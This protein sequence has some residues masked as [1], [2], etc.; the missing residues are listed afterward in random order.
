LVLL[1]PGC[2]AAM[3]PAADATYPGRNGRIAYTVVQG[4]SPPTA[5]STETVLPNGRGRRTLGE[6]GSLSWAASGRLLL[7]TT[8]TWTD[9]V[10]ARRS[11]LADD[12]GQVLHTIPVPLGPDGVPVFSPTALSPDGRTVAG[13]SFT[14]RPHAQPEQVVDWIWTI[15][16]DG[17]QLRRVARGARPRWTAN[18]RRIVFQRESRFGDY[19]GIASMRSDG[20]FKR[21]LIGGPDARFLDLAPDG[22]RLLWHGHRRGAGLFTSDL[23][24]GHPH[25]ISRRNTQGAATWSPDGTKILFAVDDLDLRGTFIARATGGSRQRLLRR[26]RFELAWQPLPRTPR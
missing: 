5:F 26:P 8:L 18:G 6:F 25:L 22:R 13:V 16:T 17:S 12:Q 10:A 20:R 7:G 4:A 21:L 24:G 1:V 23:R 3:A 11:V 15:R 2:L 9:G 14:V 19:N